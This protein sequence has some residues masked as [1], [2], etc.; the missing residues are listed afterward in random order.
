MSID[1]NAMC[2]LEEHIPDLADAAV[3][4]AYWS[5]LASGNNVLICENGAI[6]EVHPDGSKKLIKKIAPP[7]P[8]IKGQ[9]FKI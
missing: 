7:I 3:R 1:E 9:R 4:Q 6:V 2:F 5:S 8:T